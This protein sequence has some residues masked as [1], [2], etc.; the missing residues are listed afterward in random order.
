MRPEDTSPGDVLI[1]VQGIFDGPAA[2]RLE[3]TLVRAE[4]GVRFRI[5]LTQVREFQDFAIGVLAQALTRCQAD[6]ALRGL[7]RHQVRMFRYFG[8]DAAVLGG[9][10]LPDT[11]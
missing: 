4:P 8:V 1:D 3:A 10:G 11:A 7:R 9:I 5:D 2:R 6:V